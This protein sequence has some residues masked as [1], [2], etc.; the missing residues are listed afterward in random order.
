MIKD[1]ILPSEEVMLPAMPE[2]PCTM[3]P[4]VPPTPPEPA[5]PCTI[6]ENAFTDVVAPSTPAVMP[7]VKMLWIDPSA[8]PMPPLK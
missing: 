2:K 6:S 3:L 8:L 5:R 1:T 7:F 4:R